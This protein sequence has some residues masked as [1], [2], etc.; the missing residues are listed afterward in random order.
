MRRNHAV[1]GCRKLGVG[2]SEAGLQLRRLG[3]VCLLSS[4]YRRV[5]RLDFLLQLG[6]A[7]VEQC[8]LGD[9]SANR[10]CALRLTQQRQICSTSRAIGTRRCP[11]TCS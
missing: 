4:D 5:R 7:R 6:Q 10:R 3:C 9:G 11:R 8:H 1:L 2:V